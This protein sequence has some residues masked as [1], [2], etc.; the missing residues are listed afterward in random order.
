MVASGSAA[1]KMTLPF[2]S[3]CILQMYL[4]VPGCTVLLSGDGLGK[5]WGKVWVKDS[6]GSK[7]SERKAPAG[8]VANTVC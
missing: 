1:A 8:L 5:R 4:N 6:P 3:G 2:M 7:V